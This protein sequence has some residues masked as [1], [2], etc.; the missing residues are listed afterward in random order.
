MVVVDKVHLLRSKTCILISLRERMQ[1]N[2]EEKSDNNGKMRAW[3]HLQ[4][5]SCL[6]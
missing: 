1:V 6:G 5:S 4:R 3:L 2:G